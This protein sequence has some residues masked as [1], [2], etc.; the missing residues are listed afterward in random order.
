[1]NPNQQIS[2]QYDPNERIFTYNI[3]SWSNYE[4]LTLGF[5][6]LPRFIIKIST[7]LTH[8]WVKSIL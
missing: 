2:G 4:I 3:I 5:T 1:M 7:F 6:V 8:I